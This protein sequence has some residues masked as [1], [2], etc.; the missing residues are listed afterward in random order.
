MSLQF[1]LMDAEKNISEEEG[2]FKW[3]FQFWIKKIMN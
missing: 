1:Q 2:E 3:K